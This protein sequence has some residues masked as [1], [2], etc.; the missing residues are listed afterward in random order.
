MLPG[1]SLAKLVPTLGL[2]FHTFKS[3]CRT[4]R[5]EEF[6]YWSWQ[7]DAGLIPSCRSSA[8]ESRQCR[9]L[10]SCVLC[11][12]ASASAGHDREQQDGALELSR[13][14]T[15]WAKIGSFSRQG[16]SAW[17]LVHFGQRRLYEKEDHLSAI[18]RDESSRPDRRR[19]KGRGFP[20]R[21]LCARL[22]LGLA[23]AA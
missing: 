1:P 9:E 5:R 14:V 16:L 15:A 12:T 11:V 17:L 21:T 22:L 13:F 23:E 7:C 19:G 2:D 10:K 3:R 18:C 8:R 6:H 20:C 4:Q